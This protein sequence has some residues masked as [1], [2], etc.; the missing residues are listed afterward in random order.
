M[1]KKVQSPSKTEQ[2]TEWELAILN[3]LQDKEEKKSQ[4][5]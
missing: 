3:L 1:K 2:N 5:K 4:Q